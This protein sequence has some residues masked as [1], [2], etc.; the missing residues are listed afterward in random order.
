MQENITFYALHVLKK[1]FG[2]NLDV[3]CRYTTMYDTLM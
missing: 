3:D 1:E 2:R